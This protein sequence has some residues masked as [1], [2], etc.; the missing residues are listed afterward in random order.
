MKVPSLE[1]AERCVRR[2]RYKRAIQILQHVLS[3]GHSS[4][5]CYLRLAELYRLEGDWRQA[6]AVLHTAL[7]QVQDTTSVRE[8]LVEILLEN[9]N[10]A[11]AIAECEAWIQESP[12]HPTPLEH[13][14]EAYWHKMDYDHA[15]EVANR[16]VN[17]QPQSPDY[18]LQ[19][20]SLLDQLG[21][22]QE[23]I[24]DYQHLAWN[25]SVPADVM[26][27]AQLELERLDADQLDMLVPLLVEDPIFRLKF[28]HNP[29][30][31]VQ[32]RGFRFSPFGEMLL[33]Q[34]IANLR[35]MPLLPKPYAYYC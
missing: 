2:G 16:L 33:D 32:E 21:R 27:L 7:Y 10:Y 22:I 31:A 26:V 28:L 4:A 18:R 6:I 1:Q 11:E 15:L 24:E 19:R 20:A 13:L 35:K 9:G 3:Q 17:L 29:S 8:R 12:D 14:L 23:A 30:S 5:E 34:L 25:E